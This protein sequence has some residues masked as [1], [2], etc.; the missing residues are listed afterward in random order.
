[1]VN[2]PY[3][4]ALQHRVPEEE[5]GKVSGATFTVNTGLSPISTFLTGIMMERVSVTLPFVLSGCSYLASF[6]IAFSNKK[7]RNLD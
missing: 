2:V 3:W 5:L 6:F 7:L 1:M 4:T